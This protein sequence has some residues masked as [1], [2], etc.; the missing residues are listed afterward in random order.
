M[1]SFKF[2]RIVM[3]SIPFAVRLSDASVYAQANGVN[4]SSLFCKNLHFISIQGLSC[5]LGSVLLFR[6][7]Y[8]LFSYDKIFLSDEERLTVRF[9]SSYRL[10]HINSCRV[11]EIQ[12]STSRG[13]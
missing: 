11:Q 6:F 7:K 3:I 9:Y 1:S 10:Y 8:T 2:T 5:Y 12:P 4:H 13:R